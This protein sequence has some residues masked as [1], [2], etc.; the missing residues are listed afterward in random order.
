MSVMVRD[1]VIEEGGRIAGFICALVLKRVRTPFAHVRLHTRNSLGFR[2][3]N[4]PRS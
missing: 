1:P 2:S 3:S 4:I